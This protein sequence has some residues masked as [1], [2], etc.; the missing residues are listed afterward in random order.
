ML[1]IP[2][3]IAATADMTSASTNDTEN[4]L[5][6]FVQKLKNYV[7]KSDS[8]NYSLKYSERI[9]SVRRSTK[10]TRNARAGVTSIIVIL[11]V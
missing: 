11:S 8:S 5:K 6:E 2:S 10:V 1:F 9:T 7:G 3:I 4:F